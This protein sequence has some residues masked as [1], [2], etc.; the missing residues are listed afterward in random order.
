MI[1]I[2]ALTEKGLML[3]QRIAGLLTEAYDICYKPKP[4]TE[5]VQKAFVNGDKLIF[6]C[7]TGIVIRTL[8]PVLVNK[9]LDRI[10]QVTKFH[11]LI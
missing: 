2:I 4:F 5:Q 3:A 7:A 9:K 6:I 1:R 8:A 11:D 10:F